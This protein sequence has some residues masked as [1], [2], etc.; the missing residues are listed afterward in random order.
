MEEDKCKSWFKIL[1]DSY[2]YK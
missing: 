2:I 1:A